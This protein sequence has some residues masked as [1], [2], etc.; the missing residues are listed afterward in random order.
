MIAQ[1]VCPIHMV[2]DMDTIETR[3]YKEETFPIMESRIL[4]E[5]AVMLTEVEVMVQVMQS[6]DLFIFTQN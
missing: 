4:T 3:I 5:I 2:V 6:K 1:V